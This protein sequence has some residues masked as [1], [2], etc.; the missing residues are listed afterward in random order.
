MTGSLLHLHHWIIFHPTMMEE[1]GLIFRSKR[2]PRAPPPKKKTQKCW[3]WARQTFKSFRLCFFVPFGEDNSNNF[4]TI[5][6][7]LV[8]LQLISYKRY[9]E[10]HSFNGDYLS[11]SEGTGSCG[12]LFHEIRGIIRLFH[13]NGNEIIIN[14]FQNLKFHCSNQIFCIPLAINRF[15]LPFFRLFTCFSH[16]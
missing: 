6:L 16:L 7:Y 12:Y 9:L 3:G 8:N 4:N 2:N 10:V 5:Y 15:Y 13:G 11:I 1:G 14:L